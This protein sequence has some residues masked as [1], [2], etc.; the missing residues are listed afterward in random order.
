LGA[1]GREGGWRKD[2]GREREGGKKDRGREEGWREGGMD[3]RGE[4]GRWYSGWISF[5]IVGISVES[6]RVKGYCC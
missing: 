6:A 4:G 1:R 2:R 5:T 3:E